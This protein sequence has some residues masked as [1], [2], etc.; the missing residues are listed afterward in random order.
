M[1]YSFMPT[2]CE[3]YRIRIT[4]FKKKLKEKA[5]GEGKLTPDVIDL[6]HR[7]VGLSVTLGGYQ[8]L[9]NIAKKLIVQLGGEV[10]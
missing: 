2:H 6:W 3:G 1:G 7:S 8:L 4:R 10:D 5:V 9:E